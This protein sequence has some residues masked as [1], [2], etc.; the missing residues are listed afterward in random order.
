[1]SELPA[2]KRTHKISLL[3]LNWFKG[4]D[5]FREPHCGNNTQNDGRKKRVN[6]IYMTT[7]ED[8]GTQ[9]YVCIFQSDHPGNPERDPLFG[10]LVY[11]LNFR[12]FIFL[13]FAFFAL[14]LKKYRRIHNVTN[15]LVNRNVVILLFDELYI[16][17]L[18]MS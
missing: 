7:L 18:K 15:L 14:L 4:Y 1:M 3:Y 8:H 12:T 5:I 10:V 13:T 9:N 11:F 6:E 17:I 2:K 16:L